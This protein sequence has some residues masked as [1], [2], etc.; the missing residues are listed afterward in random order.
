MTCDLSLIVTMTALSFLL[1]LLSEPRVF[2]SRF[3]DYNQ[4]TTEVQRSTQ[5]LIV[6][7]ALSPLDT[8]ISRMLLDLIFVILS[9]SFDNI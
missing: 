3:A 7:A 1:L 6:I 2:P 8:A 5:R 4:A 9:L